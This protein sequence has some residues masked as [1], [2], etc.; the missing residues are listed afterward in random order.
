VGVRRASRDMTRP[1][2]RPK[3]TPA[4]GLTS[5]ATRRD[6]LSRHRQRTGATDRPLPPPSI[7]GQG[8]AMGR[9]DGIIGGGGIG[10]G[11]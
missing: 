5:A 4:D 11:D 3:C 7:P 6:H 9:D 1:V 10:D 8:D 2:S